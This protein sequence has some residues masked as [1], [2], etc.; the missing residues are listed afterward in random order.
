MLLFAAATTM[1]TEFMPRQSSS[2]VALNNFMRN[3]FSF[4]GT[5]LA[6]P[7]INAI[8]NGAMFTIIAGIALASCLVIVAMKRYGERWRVEM[9]KKMRR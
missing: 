1:L 5:L 9:D 3:I 4:A 8:G 6:E 2:G 7:L